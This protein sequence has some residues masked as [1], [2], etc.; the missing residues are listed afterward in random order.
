MASI[1]VKTDPELLM[2][3]DDGNLWM[4]MMMSYGN[5]TLNSD[6]PNITFV[7]T[8][9][10]VDLKFCVKHLLPDSSVHVDGSLESLD[11][12]DCVTKEMASAPSSVHF[13]YTQP[14]HSCDTGKTFTVKL[15]SEFYMM[16]LLQ[17]YT[18]F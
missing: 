3:D 10:T 6:S 11:N 9:P 2:D 14:T 5:L 4:E 18:V 1:Y 15:A 8:S 17:Q 16:E 7:T 12:D 13:G